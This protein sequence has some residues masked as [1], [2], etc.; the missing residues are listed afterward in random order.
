MRMFLYM[1]TILVLAA[2]V[3][4]MVLGNVFVGILVCAVYGLSVCA[5]ALVS[6]GDDGEDEWDW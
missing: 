5:I 3:A 2:S 1:L 6:Q 4:I